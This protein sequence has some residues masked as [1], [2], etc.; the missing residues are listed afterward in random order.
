MTSRKLF[1]DAVGVLL[2]YRDK[3]LDELK[4]IFFSLCLIRQLS[5][6]VIHFVVNEVY[7]PKFLNMFVNNIYIYTNV[8][9]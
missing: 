1:V 8:S 7:E 9:L 5:C 4:M 2:Q 3:I 6:E